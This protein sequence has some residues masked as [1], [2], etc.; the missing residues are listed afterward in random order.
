MQSM[1]WLVKSSE[2]LLKLWLVIW[3]LWLAWTC[4]GLL[5]QVS[6]F[7]EVWYGV[8]MFWIAGAEYEFVQPL[9]ALLIQVRYVSANPTGPLHVG[10][11][12]TAYGIALVN[13]LRAAG[14]NVQSRYYINDTGNQIMYGVPLRMPLSYRCYW[15]FPPKRKT[16]LCL[17]RYLKGRSV[18]LKMAIVAQIL[19]KQQKRCWT[20]R[21]W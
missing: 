6:Y 21:L 12:G 19:L 5:A 9:R 18:F 14:Y 20:W 11:G 7:F 1:L 10:H 8:C 17:V 16:A 3:I 4:W 13:L 2:L 15:Y